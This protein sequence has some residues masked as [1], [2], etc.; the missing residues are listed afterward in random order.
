MATGKGKKKLGAE[1]PEEAVDR[2]VR[3]CEQTGS[4]KGLT[5]TAAIKLVEYAPIFLRELA[6]KGAD[7]AIVEWFEQAE[8]YVAA[9][10]AATDA[11]ES[12]EA[13]PESRPARRRKATGS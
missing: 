12:A 4:A 8:Q 1:I 9:R 10:E 11:L 2:F 7:G 6:L 13:R 3:F 5:A